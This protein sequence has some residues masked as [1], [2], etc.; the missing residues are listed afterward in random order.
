ME[1]L[2]QGES[3]DETAHDAS[4]KLRCPNNGHQTNEVV[5]STLVIEQV[6]DESNGN[7]E[8]VENLTCETITSQFRIMSP[9]RR[10]IDGCKNR[11]ES[12]S[13]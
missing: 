7:V 10:S 11:S 4:F 9:A 12:G 3:E 5:E 1:Y 13:P 2:D 8:E 6:S